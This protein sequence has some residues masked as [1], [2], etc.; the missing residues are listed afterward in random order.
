MQDTLGTRLKWARNAA[1]LTQRDVARHI[2]VSPQA[3]Q[4]IEAGTSK[5]T[6]YVHRLANALSVSINWLETGAGQPRELAS[7]NSVEQAFAD[8]GA[9]EIPEVLRAPSEPGTKFCFYPPDEITFRPNHLPVYVSLPLLFPSRHNSIFHDM[10]DAGNE[11]FERNRKGPPSTVSPPTDEVLGVCLTALPDDYVA[12]PAYLAGQNTAYGLYP[13]FNVSMRPRLKGSELLHVDPSRRPDV[14]DI[15]VVWRTD[16]TSLIAEFVSESDEFIA[17]NIYYPEP[18]SLGLFLIPLEE[19]KAVHT[20]RGLEFNEPRSAKVKLGRFAL[21]KPN[22]PLTTGVSGLGGV[23]PTKYE[24]PE[25]T[26]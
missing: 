13:V 25:E 19:I 24:G 4:H 12:R 20:V 14:D 7:R 22:S 15:V 3:I 26:N 18:W 8:L 1:G 5:S 2:G 16:Y 21:L 6:R 10:S 23:D 11:L 17:V 9:E